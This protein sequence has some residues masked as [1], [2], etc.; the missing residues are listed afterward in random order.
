MYIQELAWQLRQLTRKWSRD[1]KSSEKKMRMIQANGIK[2]WALVPLGYI[3]RSH[4]YC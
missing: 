1:P 3:S 4:L 2:E